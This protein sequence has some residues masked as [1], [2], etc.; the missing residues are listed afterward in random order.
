MGGTIGSEPVATTTCLGGVAYPVDFDHAR[1]GELTVAAQQVDVRARQPTLLTGVGVVRDHV[2]A[3]GEGG[4]DVDFGRRRC[5]ACGRDRLAGTQERLGRDARPVRA[6]AP[7]QFAF[8]ERDAE[9][10]LGER[11]RAVFAGRT[12]TE[13][14]HVVVAHHRSI[15]RAPASVQ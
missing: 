13:H 14:D 9:S 1:S 12:S 7:D 15:V 2:V 6:L 8:D 4:L 3:P 11:P 5:V 10:A